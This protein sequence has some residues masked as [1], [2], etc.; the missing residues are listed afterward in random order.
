MNKLTSGRFLFTVVTAMVF[1]WS[2]VY[3]LLSSEQVV[4]VVMLVV[5]F[6]FHKNREEKE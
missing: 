4:S 6:Y 2:S 3:D 5:A 1:A